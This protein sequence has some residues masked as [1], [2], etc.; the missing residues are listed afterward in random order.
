M[1]SGSWRKHPHHIYCS[2]AWLKTEVNVF[3][4]KKNAC[5]ELFALELLYFVSELLVLAKVNQK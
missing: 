4:Q 1:A 2:Y 5:M 3:L